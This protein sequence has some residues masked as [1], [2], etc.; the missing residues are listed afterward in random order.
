MTLAIFANH[1]AKAYARFAITSVA[2]LMEA[3]HL[4]L[5]RILGAQSRAPHKDCDSHERGGSANREL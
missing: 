5:T 1:D 4:G 3:K 2:E